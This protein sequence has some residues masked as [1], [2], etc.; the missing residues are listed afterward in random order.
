MFWWRQ[1]AAGRSLKLAPGRGDFGW[2]LLPRSAAAIHSA[3][4][5]RIPNLPIERRTLYHWA[6]AAPF[7]F[8]HFNQKSHEKSHAR[9][10]HWAALDLV[11]SPWGHFDADS[12]PNKAPRP[13]NWNMKYYKSVGFLSIFRIFQA[14]LHKR[15]AFLSKTFRKNAITQ[16]FRD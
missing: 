1:L 12:P 5:D 14:P 7:A 2:T 11:S 9:P 13:P 16:M 3:T 4:V 15:K 8:I 6:I 10:H